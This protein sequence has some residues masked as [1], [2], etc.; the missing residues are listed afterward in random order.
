[1]GCLTSKSNKDCVSKRKTTK[2]K[3]ILVKKSTPTLSEEDFHQSHLLGRGGFGEVTVQRLKYRPTHSKSHTWFAVKKMK[4]K[5]ILATK[6]GVEMIM[7]ELQAMKR[8][9]H[10]FVVRMHFAYNTDLCCYLGLDLL[11]GGDL[12]YH[13]M[14]GVSNHPSRTTIAHRASI[15]SPYLQP[16]LI[17][18]SNLIP[19]PHFQT[20]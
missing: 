11:L 16:T 18:A 6:R 7:G 13:L 20:F 15:L 8:V 12:R 17:P 3:I 5:K 4:K 19:N 2:E 9:E 10:A 1:M 14:Q